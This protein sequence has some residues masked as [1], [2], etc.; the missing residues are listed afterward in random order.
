MNMQLVIGGRSLTLNQLGNPLDNAFIALHAAYFGNQALDWQTFSGAA[1]QF[2][3]TNPAPAAH[4]QY[5]NNFTI[6]WSEFLGARR[7]TE[8][9]YIWE[10]ALEPALQWE[11]AHAGHRLHKGTPYYFWG[12]TALLRGDLDTGYLLMHQGVEEDRLTHGQNAPDTPGYALV[13]LNGDKPD[14]AFRPWVLAQAAFLDE[15]IAG[16]NH[17]HGR[18]LTIQSFKQRFLNTPPS[19]DAVFLLSYTIARLRNLAR[20]PV[21]A[22]ASQFAGQLEMNLLFDLTLVVDAAIKAKHPNSRFIEHA[23][24]LLR[25]AA[26]PLTNAELREINGAFNNDFDATMQGMLGSTY[27][28]SSGNVLNGFQCDVAIAYGVRNYGAHDVASPPAMGDRFPD[29]QQAIF[30][31]LCATVERLY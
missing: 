29:I 18:G 14:Q 20:L 11:Q 10:M 16:Y 8:A 5:F 6:I 21:H 22:T 1:L 24:T 2:F 12:M 9:E 19:T 31:V 26:Q 23:E 25:I 13:S 17:T 15:R 28:L 3:D 30:R 7:Y 27:R 4:D